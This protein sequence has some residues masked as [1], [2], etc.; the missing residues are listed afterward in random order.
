MSFSEWKKCQ[1]GDIVNF[2]RG[3]DL[4]KKNMKGGIY[5]VVG[6]NGIIG[7]HNNYTTESPCL[8]IGRSGNVGNPHIINQKCWAHNTT[9]YVDDFKGNDPMFIYYLLKTLNLGY[10]AGGSAVPTLNR[11]HI[12]PINIKFPD[13]LEE[14]KA[15]AHILS[16]FDEKIEVN[17]EI[18][19]KLEE[20][21]QAI[22]KQ[23]FV[24]FEFPNQEGK[25]YK[26]SGG[27]MIESEMGLIPKGWGIE[28]LSNL[29]KEIITGKTPSTK[30]QEN[31]G[32]K[33]PFI[34]IP[35]MHNNV[36]ITKTERYLSDIGNKSQTKKLIPKNSI[37]VSCIAT[38]GL[39]AINTTD[40]H[41]NQQINSIILNNDEDLYYFYEYLKL[42]T[43]TLKA[44]GSSG[45][46][47]L[48]VNKG[49]FAKIK[50]IYPKKQTLIKFHNVVISIFESIKNN[51][52]QIEKLVNI[53]ET[54]LPKLMSGEIR[55]P[56]NFKK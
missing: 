13:N 23:W 47:T 43:D 6:S 1:L 3:H 27:E 51:K 29:V 22:F 19:K 36:F 30:K 56:F 31:Y 54:L 20:M 35:D 9:L 11:N 49:E 41:T 16:T 17:N 4:S 37:I 26:S 18:N 24:D 2:K 10:Y 52:I 12:H 5:P 32:S 46:T 50:Y 8:T 7:Y 33:Y 42:M 34:T 21:A 25:P 28:P 45:S 39:V 38:V 15:I 53:R 14:Q 44:I 55:V 40:S 48:N